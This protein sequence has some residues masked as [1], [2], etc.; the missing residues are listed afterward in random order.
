MRFQYKLDGYDRDWIDAGDRRAAY[1]SNIPPGR[2]TFHVK[3]ANNDGVWNEAG[4]AY[5]IYLAPHFYQTPWFYAL[6]VLAFGL[7]LSGGYRLRVQDAE[8]PRA[9]PRT[10]S[11][12]SA[13]KS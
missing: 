4:D 11:S 10:R 6:S 12:T 1:Y 8:S 5:P 9:A 2:Y 13:P 7:V 3:A